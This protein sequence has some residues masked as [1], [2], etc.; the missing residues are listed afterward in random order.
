MCIEDAALTLSPHTLTPHCS[1][2]LPHPSQM[3]TLDRHPQTSW[4]LSVCFVNV[5]VSIPK[6]KEVSEENWAWRNIY[7]GNKK[8]KK[9]MADPKREE[10]VLAR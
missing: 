3:H 9:K 5:S 4:T 7:G 6:M 10:Y 2:S 1:H 8:K